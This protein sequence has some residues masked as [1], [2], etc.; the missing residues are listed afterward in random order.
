MKL[1]TF[2]AAIAVMVGMSASAQ[3]WT[4]SAVAGGEFYLLNVG[5]GEY[6]TKGN[7]WGTQ[8]SITTNGSASSALKVTLVDL[9]GIYKIQTNVNGDGYGVEYLS[10]GTI[11]TDQSRGKN[12]AWRF[13]QVGSNANGPIYTICSAGPHGGGEGKYMTASAENTIVGPADNGNSV[14]AQ[15]Q[16]VKE[17][18]TAAIYAAYI[19]KS[20]VEDYQTV[21]ATIV[22]WTTSDAISNADEAKATFNT[23][24]AAADAKVEAATSVAEVEEAIADLK[25][26]G[27]TFLESVTIGGGL[28][29]TNAWITNPAPGISGHTGGWTNS[30]SPT[31]DSQLFE[32]WNVSGGSTKQTLVNLP[33]G[34]YKLTA[35][36]YTR[37][38]MTATLYAGV[39]TTYL[40]GCGTVNTR[41]E[42]N[43]WIA[44]NETNGRSNLEF[45]LDA[46]AASLEIGLIADNA[47]G[48]HWMCWRSFS[49]TYYG[50]PINLK[51]AELAEAVAAA[52]AIAEGTIPT[53]AYNDLAA[54]V[55]ANNKAWGTEAEYDVAVAVINGAVAVAQPLVAPYAAYKAV[56]ENAAIAGVDSETISAQGTAVEE[57]TTVAAIEACTAALKAAIAPIAAFDITSFTITNASPYANGDDW[58][59]TNG[60]R[61]S[62]WA[63]NPV[64]YDVDNKCAEM[65]SN[66]GASMLYTI[67]N[68]PAGAYR[69]TAIAGARSNTGGVLK[70]G[71][72]TVELVS[73]GSVNSRSEANTWFNEGNGVNELFFTL[74]DAAA[75]LT[76]GLVAGTSGDAWTLWR[77]FKLETFDESVAAG[78]LAPG[79]APLVEEAQ[80]TLA[81]AAYAN[82]TGEERT[83]LETAIAATPGTVEEF[84][85]ATEAINTAI[86]AFKAAKTNYDIYATERTLADAISTDI[87][88]AS[89]TTAENALV[90]FRALKV[91]EYNYVAD[92]YKFSATSK[93]GE[94]STWERTGTVN[95]T[96]RM[97]SR[98]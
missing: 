48:D 14:Y 22:A 23:A 49:L 47:T 85:A 35:I 8:A 26:A 87:V 34:A 13:D 9:D 55:T 96:Q 72:K 95:G 62:Q 60:T 31:L 39:N 5:S 93:I 54:T 86:A 50:D 43:N 33:K 6:F 40:V 69:L 1:K 58:T 92:A 94:F 89:P 17:S 46:A 81:D 52:Q 84:E 2:L 30:G 44:A 71:D 68:L 78:Y 75:E 79:Y 24:L 56:A 66:Q 73:V 7:G 12:S 10:G 90:Q 4:A 88:V 82:V 28:D 98:L 51:K 61:V 37:D 53:A 65:W 76:I 29:I 77:S 41:G 11:Y 91:A 63:S 67:N 97:S 80:A 70:V 36:A 42:G 83:N 27:N 20:S 16:L 59:A 74:D 64:T 15:W 45:T 19:I 32:Y 38:N 25:A 3:S 18:E 21:R 57:A